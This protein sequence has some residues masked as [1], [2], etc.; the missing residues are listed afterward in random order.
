MKPITVSYTRT[1]G[2]KLTYTITADM[3]GGFVIK[4]GDQVMKSSPVTGSYF[5]RKPWGDSRAQELGVRAAKA[6]IEMLQG[7]EE[8]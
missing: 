1:Q 7:M 3:H 2:R 8:G 5:G 6:A 4:L